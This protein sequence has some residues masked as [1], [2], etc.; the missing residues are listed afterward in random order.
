MSNNWKIVGLNPDATTLEYTRDERLQVRIGDWI[1]VR[2]G[3]YRIEQTNR[4][5]NEGKVLE[6]ANLGKGGMQIKIKARRSDRRSL[7]NNPT[8]AGEIWINATDV[9]GKFI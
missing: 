4:Y 1:D 3:K 5:V 6:F 9:M 2:T 8:D 7:G